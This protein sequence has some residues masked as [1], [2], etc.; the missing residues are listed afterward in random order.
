MC[1]PQLAEELGSFSYGFDFRV[2]KKDTRKRLWNVPPKLRKVAKAR[3]M[4]G[5]SCMEAIA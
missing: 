5:N 1:R 4:S 3:C 2:K